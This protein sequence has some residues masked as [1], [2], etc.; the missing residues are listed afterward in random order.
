[1]S[2][3][4]V[5]DEIYSR[6]VEKEAHMNFVRRAAEVSFLSLKDCC[7]ETLAA[8]CSWNAERERRSNV[9]TFLPP[10]R[11][12]CRNVRSPDVRNV[13]APRQESLSA[14]LALPLH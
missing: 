14:G 1:M 9:Q 2:S 6:L 7:Q 11:Q 8:F 5:L 13:L 4:A 10:Q 12:A 3:C